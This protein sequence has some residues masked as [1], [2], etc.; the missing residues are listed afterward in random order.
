MVVEKMSSTSANS[1]LE[2]N[3]TSRE[4][5]VKYILVTTL[6]VAVA[7]SVAIVLA[8]IVRACWRKRQG[9]KQYRPVPTTD[10]PQN[11]PVKNPKVKIVLPDPPPPK[12]RIT[13]ATDLATKLP[14]YLP[15]KPIATGNSRRNPPGVVGVA[16]P[17]A[18]LCLKMCL[19]HDRLMIE[20]QN[21][22]GLPC[23]TDGT[24]ADLFVKL[25]VVSRE[26]KRVKRSPS[27]T[28]PIQHSNDPRFVQTLDCG[29][30]VREEL[31]HTILHIEVFWYRQS[32][33]LIFILL[34]PYRYWITC[35]FHSMLCLLR[36][37]LP[38]MK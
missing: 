23:R 34:S 5:N 32:V 1:T 12:T 7:F 21:A 22:I 17:Q 2:E 29:S 36:L 8:F 9:S 35:L 11:E 4:D 18:F 26:K 31:E 13:L 33:T 27:G 19:D 3:D 16:T 10:Y 30:V 28:L 24:P 25:N 37:S 15:H 14:P 20:V 6:S 38:S